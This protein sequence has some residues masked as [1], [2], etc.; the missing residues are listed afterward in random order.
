MR[1]GGQVV[2]RRSRKPKIMGSNPIHAW[3]QS[4]KMSCAIEIVVIF[5][6]CDGHLKALCSARQ[7][8]SWNNTVNEEVLGYNNEIQRKVKR[9]LMR[10]FCTYSGV[11]AKW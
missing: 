4:L 10:R 7:Y 11:V 6:L 3:T 5:T 8:S 9:F 2:R 1:R